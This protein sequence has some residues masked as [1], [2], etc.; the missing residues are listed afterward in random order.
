MAGF[1]IVAA[2]TALADRFGE[3]PAG[4]LGGIPTSGPVS[5]LFIGITQS[6]SAAEK[7]TLLF[8]LGF[9]STFA[10]LLFYAIPKEARFSVRM[11]A[12]LCLW[13]PTS[14]AI[15]TWAPDDFVVSLAASLVVAVVVL[16]LRRRIVTVKTDSV[17]TS[18][19]A[20][21]SALRGT[22]GGLVVVSVVILSEVIGP[23]VGGVFAA[24]PAIWSSSLYVT[25][26]TRGMEFSRSLT[27]SFM[28]TSIF[29]VIPYG[30]AARYF[31]EAS[32]IWWG[33][34]FSFA[35]ISP[36]AYLAWRLV[37]VG[38]RTTRT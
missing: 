7:A 28:Q 20:R 26:R 31:F 6:Q 22:L 4:F 21:L 11:T 17:R 33:T 1:A 9:S 3:G 2:V 14:A 12:A 37:V 29:T 5:L 13:L 38:D 32:G 16:F 35:A 24:A 25:S 30:V 15:A 19:T 36:L 18:P 23:Q 8:P 10:F 34:L 27:L